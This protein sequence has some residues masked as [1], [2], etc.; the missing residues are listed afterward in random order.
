MIDPHPM[1]VHADA[2]GQGDHGTLCATTPGNLSDPCS[3]P[4][5]SPTVHHDGGSLTQR[6]AQGDVA[7][8]GDPT[9]DIAF[10]RLVSRRRE[11]YP[12][13]YL[14]LGGEAGRII[15]SGSVGQ[16]DDRTDPRHRHQP[17]IHW[18]ILGEVA[19][20]AF[21]AALTPDPSSI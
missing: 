17:T 1:Q 11:T 16:R 14:L 8:F 21:Q 3:Q 13:P 4:C 5:R 2:P 6:S 15:D 18:V 20:T 7:G 10:A 9:R 12:W 19:D